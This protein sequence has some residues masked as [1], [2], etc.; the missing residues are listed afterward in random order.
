MYSSYHELTEDGNDTSTEKQSSYHMEEE[1]ET[2]L[3]EE[4]IITMVETAAKR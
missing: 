1:I 2:K 3:P 4:Q